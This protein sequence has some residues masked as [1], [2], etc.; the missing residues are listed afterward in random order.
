MVN[1][2]CQLKLFETQVKITLFIKISPLPLSSYPLILLSLPSLVITII[3]IIL[4]IRTQVL[5]A[6]KTNG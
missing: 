3:I 2:N 1:D 4:E 5:G 6:R